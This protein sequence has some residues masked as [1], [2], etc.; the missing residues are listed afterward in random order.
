M[1]LTNVPPDS[2]RSKKSASDNSSCAGVHFRTKNYRQ[3]N[4]VVALLVVLVVIESSTSSSAGVVLVVVI[5]SRV[6]VVVLEL[7]EYDG[8]LAR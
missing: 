7:V 1:S 5:E 2:C 3:Q 6:L 4:S 8:G